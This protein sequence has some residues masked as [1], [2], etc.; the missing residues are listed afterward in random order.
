MKADL[1]MLQIVINVWC[2]YFSLFT[3]YMYAPHFLSCSNSC[4]TENWVLDV[5]RPFLLWSGNEANSFVF[6]TYYDDHFS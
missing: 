5:A 1:F 2:L 4:M 6:Q 3:Y